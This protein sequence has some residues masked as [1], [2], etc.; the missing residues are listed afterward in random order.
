MRTSWHNLLSEEKRAKSTKKNEWRGLPVWREG[1]VGQVARVVVGSCSSCSGRIHAQGQR[2]HAEGILGRGIG[3]ETTEI[4]F[5]YRPRGHCIRQLP[6][7]TEGKRRG[8]CA[9]EKSHG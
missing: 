6:G 7:Q 3:P 1:R 9:R 4:L 2:G 5:W 8:E